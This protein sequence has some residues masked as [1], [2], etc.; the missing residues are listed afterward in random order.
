MKK[1]LI[2]FAALIA[3]VFCMISFNSCTAENERENKIDSD[4]V[5]VSTN[6]LATVE[7]P[8]GESLKYDYITF[9]DAHDTFDI[10]STESY[11]EYEQAVYAAINYLRSETEKLYLEIIDTMESSLYSCYVLPVHPDMK[12]E[13]FRV[14][15]VAPFMEYYEIRKEAADKSMDAFVGI[16]SVTT[17]P[18]AAGGRSALLCSYV[19]NYNLYVEILEI[20]DSISIK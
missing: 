3:M 15:F 12:P 5:P 19:T 18:T 20:R 9:S 10:K 13:E 2:I 16:G 8:E 6:T 11:Y 7:K 4:T 1:A 14:L 17:Y